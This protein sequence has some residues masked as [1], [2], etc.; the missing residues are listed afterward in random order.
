MGTF[1]A[2]HNLYERLNQKKKDE[3]QDGAI[4]KLEDKFDQM[5]KKKDGDSDKDDLKD[6]LDKS[7]RVIKREYD[8]GYDRLGRR[9]AVGDS[10][11]PLYPAM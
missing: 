2:S 9:Y 7:G 10:K 1:A 5:S 4:K 11:L 3:N 8:A 6:S